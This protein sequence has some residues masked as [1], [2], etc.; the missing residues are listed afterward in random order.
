MRRT[1]LCWQCSSRIPTW[2][3]S[4]VLAQILGLSYSKAQVSTQNANAEDVKEAEKALKKKANK[5]TKKEAKK[6]KKS[7]A[8]VPA[9]A[10]KKPDQ[11]IKKASKKKAETQSLADTTE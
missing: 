4:K 11:P 7:A 9:A 8:K 6:E 1:Y 2:P 5:V 10:E 3:Y